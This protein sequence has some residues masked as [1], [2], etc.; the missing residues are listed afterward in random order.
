[1]KKCW[2]ILQGI[3]SAAACLF[4][5]LFLGIE[6]QKIVCGDWLL[7][8]QPMIGLLQFLLRFGVAAGVFFSSVRNA[9]GKRG[10]P[11]EGLFITV[12]CAVT[13]PLLPNG[14]GILFLLLS[15]G[16]SVMDFLVYRNR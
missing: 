8:E 1:M 7:H 13:A 15:A 6:G 14:F 11:W 5:V 10:T 4:A 2:R 16:I 9:A 3:L 12:S